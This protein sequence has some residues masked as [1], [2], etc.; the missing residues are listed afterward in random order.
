MYKPS[1]NLSLNNKERCLKYLTQAYLSPVQSQKL[2]MV[3]N[4]N[5][6]D[7]IYD[8]SMFDFLDL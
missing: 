2:N 3:E 8:L 6:V 7:Q 5:K 1:C 4:V